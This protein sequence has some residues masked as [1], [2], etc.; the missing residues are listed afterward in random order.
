MAKKKETVIESKVPE[1]TQVETKN[2]GVE[3]TS[4]ESS[5]EEGTV[6]IDRG[7]TIVIPYAKE[8]AQGKELLYALRSI[9]MCMRTPY[10]VVIIGDREEWLSEE[11]TVIPHTRVSDNPQIDTLD[12]LTVAIDSELV[13]DKFIWTNDD[14]YLLHPMTVTDMEVQ[15]IKGILNP[16]KYAGAYRENM[17]RTIELL[18]GG[19]I[20]DYETHTPIVYE[21]ELLVQ[22]FELYPSISLSGYLIPSLYFN[23]FFSEFIPIELDWKNDQWLLPVITQNWDRETILQLLA[24]KKF[25]NNAETGYSEK[26]ASILEELFPSEK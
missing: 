21:K 20:L 14:I 8:F 6:E 1:V 18:G 17:I 23:T 26:F 9:K 24:K 11:I 7:I 5:S 16:D 22:L 15:K 3:K 10:N 13:S 12:K 4:E 2:A 19:E 25:L